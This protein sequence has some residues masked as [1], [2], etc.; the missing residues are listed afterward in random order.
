MDNCYCKIYS[1]VDAVE[2]QQKISI[3]SLV[4][5]GRAF[6]ETSRGHR[7]TRLCKSKWLELHQNERKLLWKSIEKETRP[8]WHFETKL[9]HRERKR[10]LSRC[11]SLLDLGLKTKGN[12]KNLIF[13]S[14]NV[15]WGF[16]KSFWIFKF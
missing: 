7:W 6:R 5:T 1:T 10:K 8:H 12:G 4:S 13:W 2:R 9:V 14:S 15:L 11:I 16:K 3:W